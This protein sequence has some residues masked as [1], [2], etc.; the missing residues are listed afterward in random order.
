MYFFC[1]NGPHHPGPCTV[2]TSSGLLIATQWTAKVV[3]M[4]EY[5]AQAGTLSTHRGQTSTPQGRRSQRSTA[6]QARSPAGKTLNNPSLPIQH[7]VANAQYRLNARAGGREQIA[8]T[9]WLDI[10]TRS[11]QPPSP[12]TT[13]PRQ[14]QAPFIWPYDGLVIDRDFTSVFRTRRDAKL[15]LF[16]ANQHVQTSYRSFFFFLLS[17]GR[18]SLSC[19]SLFVC[20][21]AAR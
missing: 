8:A 16:A 17:T 4:D 20:L 6:L 19:S 15:L 13:P 21:L 7:A 14:R 12:P 10:T 2:H 3:R 18:S 1:L 11:V 9:Q 5:T